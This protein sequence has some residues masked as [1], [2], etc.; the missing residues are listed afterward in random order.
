M[1]HLPNIQSTASNSLS[2]CQTV[3]SQFRTTINYTATTITGTTGINVTCSASGV[4][5]PGTTINGVCVWQRKLSAVCR[6]A[7]GVIKIRIQT[8]GLPPRC[9]AVP[10]STFA[11]LNVDFEVNFNPDVSI[12][13]LNSNLNT[14]GSLSQTICTLT[15]MSSVPSASGYVNYGTTGLDTA[16][17]VAVDGVMMFTSDSANNYDPFFPPSGGTA[18]TVDSCLAHCQTAGIYHYH[19]AT[20]CQVNPPTGNITSCAAVSACNSNIATYSIS[21]FSSY[22][23]K[24][25]IGV[26]RDGHVIYGP[27][28]SSG[29][30]V[31]TGFDVCNGMF[32][33]S[34][35]NYAYFATSTYPYIVGCFGPGNYPSFGPNCTTNGVSTYNMSSYAISFLSSNTTNTTTVSTTMVTNSTT[36]STTRVTNSTTMATN[37]T[38]ASTTR[39]TNSTTVHHSASISGRINLDTGLILLLITA[40]IWLY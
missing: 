14:V 25:V 40:W 8:N 15:S 26:A 24:T 17:G 21:S 20:G 6:N 9:A 29:T 30:R 19:I 2:D 27:Y 34:I 37:S 28:L 13:S 32:Y 7:S 31:T 11:E 39:V 4:T 38:T 16:T 12:N 5:C 23:T 36:A 1:I 22:Q 10:S 18:E 33:D 3:A 35:G